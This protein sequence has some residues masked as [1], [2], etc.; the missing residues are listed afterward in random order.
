[1]TNELVSRLRARRD[2][3]DHSANN[4][5]RTVG[6]P[7][8][9]L[10]A[11]DEIERLRNA[12][13]DNSL[14]SDSGSARMLLERVL[15]EMRIQRAK[16]VRL[17]RDIETFLNDGTAPEPGEGLTVPL[18][19][20][21]ALKADRD[22]WR[23]RTAASAGE[24]HGDEPCHP[25]ANCSVCSSTSAP[26]AAQPA[27]SAPSHEG[28]GEATGGAVSEEQQPVRLVGGPDLICLTCGTKGASQSGSPVSLSCYRSDCPNSLLSGVRLKSGEQA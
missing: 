7:D 14:D 12:L 15:A 4:G 26:S 6:P 13:N 23:E 18:K 25:D 28:A 24:P 16:N 9:E 17:Q 3:I 22:D 1:M 10:Q 19:V 11:A 2:V 21:N 8:I 27:V 5:W 20:Y